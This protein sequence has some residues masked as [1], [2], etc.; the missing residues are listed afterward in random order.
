MWHLPQAT[1]ACPPVS[2]QMRL[3]VVIKCR[4]HPALGVVAVRAV[5]LPIPGHELPVVSIVV[6]GFALLWRAFEPRLSLRRGLVA[7]PAGHRAVRA[8]QRKLRF[9][10]V[11]PVDVRP[12][13][14]GVARFAPKRRSIRPLPRHRSVELALVRILVA[15]RAGAILKL[16][17]QDLVHAPAH[18]KLVAIGARHS[19][20][21]P[22]QRKA[23]SYGAW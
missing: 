22:R 21:R 3:G 8:Q 4:R 14:H 17:G 6:A 10:V 5:R 7:F 18:A 20:V 16:E 11:E 9:G 23:R 2:G 1:L 15:R 13:L 12:G 19:H